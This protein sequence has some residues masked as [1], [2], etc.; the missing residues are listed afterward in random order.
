MREAEI[1][2]TTFRGQP[3]RRQKSSA[4]FFTSVLR[5]ALR[6]I[7]EEIVKRHLPALKLHDGNKQ[8]FAAAES[9]EGIK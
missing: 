8:L 3:G 7:R 2:K 4:A 5:R 9:T 1:R 6:L